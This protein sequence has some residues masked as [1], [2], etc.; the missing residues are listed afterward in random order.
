MA[1]RKRSRRSLKDSLL[2]THLSWK[3]PKMPVIRD[4]KMIDGSRKTLVDPDYERRYRAHM[5][6]NAEQPS[7]R[8]DPTYNLRKPRR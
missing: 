6:E 4:Y 5:I 8:Q 3:N 1:P 7:Y 2:D